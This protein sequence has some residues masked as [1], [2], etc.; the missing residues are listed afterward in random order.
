MNT[1]NANSP[2]VIPVEA[3]KLEGMIRQFAGPLTSAIIDELTVVFQNPTEAA[4]A[5]VLRLHRPWKLYTDCGH[6]HVFGDGSVE[7][8][9]I[10]LTCEVM[11]DICL[12]CCTDGGDYQSENCASNHAHG[13]DLPI[14]KTAA[15]I[16]FELGD[17]P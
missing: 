3:G 6:K 14:C 5:A 4:L 17:K 13:K 11:Y 2:K 12:E 15:A 1:A 16:A 9:D 8:E 10:G 7:I